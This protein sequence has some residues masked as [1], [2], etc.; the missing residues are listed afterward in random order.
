MPTAVDELIDRSWAAAAAR[1]DARSGATIARPE[2]E[3]LE[4]PR[5]ESIFSN[6][7]PVLA[8]LDAALALARGGVLVELA[9]AYEAARDEILWT[10]NAAYDEQRVGRELLD[11]YAYACLSG[12]DGPQ[13]CEAPLC[14]YILLAPNMSYADHRHAP[15]EFY[16]V[17]TPGAQWSL[18]SGEWFDVQAG[19]LIVHESWQMHATRTGDKPM[20]AFAA[21]LER[22]DRLA[23]EI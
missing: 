19:D 22:G 7:F 23:I 15:R 20:L 18:N 1:V 5:S 9:E 12:P 8:H 11:K 13:R 2:L 10:Q 6:E 14:G 16:L 21:W 17:L 4:A 3:P